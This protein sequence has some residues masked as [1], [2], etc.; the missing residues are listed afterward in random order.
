VKRT[1]AWDDYLSTLEDATAKPV[2]QK[3]GHGI[4]AEGWIR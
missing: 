3:A 2:F 1:T 4:M